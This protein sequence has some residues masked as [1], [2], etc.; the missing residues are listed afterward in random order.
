MIC[1]HCTVGEISAETDQCVLCGASPGGQVTVDR[2]V[3]DETQ[4]TVQRELEGRFKIAGLIGRGR[5]STVFLAQDAE[6]DQPVAVKVIPLQRGLYPD[7]PQFE[8]DTKVAASLTHSHLLPV[9]DSGSTPALLWY[10]MKYVKGESLAD[11]LREEGPIELDLCLTVMEQA[12][13]ALDY[14]HRRGLVHGNVKPSNII[15]DSNR[16]ARLCDPIVMGAFGASRGAA[17]GKGS[18]GTPEYAAPERF[19]A[20]TGTASIDQYALA[21]VAYECLSG[22]LPF[23]GDAPDEIE[24]QHRTEVP[25]LLSSV[26]GDIP[27]HVD[28]AI[29]RAMSKSVVERFPNVLDFVSLLRGDWAPEEAIPIVPEEAA[30]RPQVVL[31]DRSG[32]EDEEDSLPVVLA[33]PPRRRFPLGRL[34]L[35]I[36]TVI[37]VESVLLWRRPAPLSV[38]GPELR[39]VTPETFTVNEQPPVPPEGSGVAVPVDSGVTTAG[40][41]DRPDG[42]ADVRTERVRPNAESGAAAP[43]PEPPTVR[44]ER[45]TPRPAATPPPQRPVRQPETPPAQTVPVEADAGLLFVNSTPWGQLY[46]DGEL[47]GNTPKAN[48]LLTPGTHHIR[49]TRDGFEPFEIEIEVA[50]R[51]Q[52][53]LT[54]IVLKAQNEEDE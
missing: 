30:A 44:D 2:P 25:P 14:L 19:R 26:R 10:S 52:V 35:A 11:L 15:V 6:R 18:V 51:Q 16:W 12:G 20:R 21:V 34:A 13:S 28:D 38:G 50:P 27:S 41:S 4:E 32:V 31:I 53:R 45:P 29:Q 22:T 49:V 17:A 24:R 1:P 39:M 5:R 3:V 46:L 54:S 47:I 36:L 43:E 42:A 40:V 37:L 33:P 48:L 9:Y 23:V 7:L 8:R